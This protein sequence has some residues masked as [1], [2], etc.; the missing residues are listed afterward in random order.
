MRESSEAL[1]NDLQK[2]QHENTK[3]TK[4]FQKVMKEDRLSHHHEPCASLLHTRSI[5]TRPQ[6]IL[7]R[8]CSTLRVTIAVP[9]AIEFVIV[10]FQ[11]NATRR[12]REASRVEFRAR[13][14]FQ[15]LALDSAVA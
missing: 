15:V 12:A 5:T 10:V 3:K 14:G 2:E 6:E 8:G 1:E 7:G 4:K 9:L 11:D 13:I